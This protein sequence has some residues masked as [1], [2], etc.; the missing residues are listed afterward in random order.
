MKLAKEGVWG[1]VDDAEL[2]AGFDGMKSDVSEC[3][4][5]GIV[6]GGR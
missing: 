3:S 4:F 1:A 2:V 5:V 6:N